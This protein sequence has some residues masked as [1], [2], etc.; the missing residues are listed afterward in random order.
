MDNKQAQYLDKVIEKLLDATKID[1]DPFYYQETEI[2][3]PSDIDGEN[4]YTYHNLF[5]NR[6]KVFVNTFRNKFYKHC[7]DIYGLTEDESKDVWKQYSKR[8]RQ[9]IENGWRGDQWTEW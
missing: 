1:Y 5:I 9:K 2:I 8:I 4:I 7:R 6:A 3:I